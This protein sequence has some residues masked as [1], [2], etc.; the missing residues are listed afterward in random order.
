MIVIC[1]EKRICISLL[2]L[3]MFITEAAD[4]AIL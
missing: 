3:K 4:V 2:E 1:S